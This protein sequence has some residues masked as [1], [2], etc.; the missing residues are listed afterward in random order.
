MRIKAVIA[1]LLWL[2][3]GAASAQQYARVT[4]Y[5]ED[6]AED[7]QGHRLVYAVKEQVRRSAGMQLAEVEKDSTFQL[8]LSSIDPD[9]TNIRAA[10]SVVFTL[11]NM[12]APGS[13][14]LYLDSTNGICGAQVID[15]CADS[16][17]ARLDRT[18]SNLRAAF[19]SPS[20]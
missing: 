19:S 5:V 16:I 13:F 6:G 7:T 3:C 1:I 14:P 10:Y 15:Q 17:V 9:N 12:S 8:H 4:V 2:A 11:V 20:K 18:V